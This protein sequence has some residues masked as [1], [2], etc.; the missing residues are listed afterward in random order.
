MSKKITS[1]SSNVSEELSAYG[2]NPRTITVVGNAVDEELFVP[3]QSKAQTNSYVLFVGIF[4]SGKGVFD[5]LNCAKYV[6]D[7]RPDIRFVLCGNGPLLK[8]MEECVKKMGLQR[9]IVFLGYI[10][11]RNR[12]SKLY[13][14]AT[15]LVQ[16]SYHEGF[17]TVVLEAMS[18]GLPVVAND[19]A[20]NR[21]IISSRSNGILVPPRSP[22]AMANSVLELLNDAS[23]RDRIGR[24]ARATVE[25]YYTWDNI[26]DTVIEC[27]ESVLQ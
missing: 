13:Q 27:Y 5:V 18:C 23:L 22:E 24:A 14:N 4:R 3:K 20:G 1:V 8:S 16:P 10:A 6:C 2:L 15:L 25:N 12:L 19:I 9:Q 7:K 11:D 17:S 21:T 26:A